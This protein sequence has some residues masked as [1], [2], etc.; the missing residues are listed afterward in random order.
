MTKQK[1]HTN[2]HTDAYRYMH[3]DTH[4]VYYAGTAIPTLH[5][6]NSI[7]RTILFLVLVLV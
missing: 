7:L 4:A 1:K 5:S 6:R 2:K 3:S